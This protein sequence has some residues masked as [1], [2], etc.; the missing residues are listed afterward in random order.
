MSVFLLAPISFVEIVP[1]LTAVM[2]MFV[3]TQAPTSVERSP[4]WASAAKVLLASNVMFLS[5]Q[6]TPKVASVET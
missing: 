4:S 5:A 2:L 6:I 1:S 3:S